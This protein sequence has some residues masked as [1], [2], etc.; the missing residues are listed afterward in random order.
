MIVT[1]TLNPSV[2]IS[3]KMEEFIIDDVN[4]CSNVSKTPGGKGLNVA[5]VLKQLQEAVMATGFLGGYT[6]EFIES[7]LKKLDIKSN[8]LKIKG[9]TRNCIAILNNGNQTEILEAGEKVPLEEQNKF[10]EFLEETIPEKSVITI[11]GSMPPG[12]E[13]DYYEKIIAIG[14]KKNA[15]IILDTSGAS[16][17]NV[18]RGNLKPFGI[19]PNETEIK[20]IENRNL[21]NTGELIEY[22][23]SELFRGIELIVVTMGSKGALVKNKNDFYKVELP[24]I[25]AINPVGSGDS[26]VA[27]LSYGIENNLNIEEI[28]KYSMACGV[29]NAMEEKT[30]YINTDNLEKILKQIKIT[31]V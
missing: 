24:K 31:K 12:I 3:Y 20:Q 15:K 11:S 28:I 23:K 21:K 5:R 18:L 19:K 2:D 29:L 14:N 17:V 4:R 6:G 13:V 30:G 10:L 9:S 27:G 7:E 8:F 25:K 26:S 1:I 16:L 22:L